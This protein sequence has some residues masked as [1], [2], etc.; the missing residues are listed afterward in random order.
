MSSVV[1]NLTDVIANVRKNREQVTAQV[2]A[3]KNQLEQ[4]EKQIE[5]I[6]T[7]VATLEVAMASDEALVNIMARVVV[8]AAPQL[9]AANEGAA[10]GPASAPV[11]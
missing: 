9:A 7:L 5:A 11:V 3:L 10:S 8:N 2:V 6:D 1:Q 4:T